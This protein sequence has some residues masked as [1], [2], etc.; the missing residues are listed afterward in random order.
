MNLASPPVLIASA[1]LL[2]LAASLLML[3]AHRRVHLLA[4]ITWL[5][6]SLQLATL[7]LCLQTL[8][9]GLVP[10][11]PLLP[12]LPGLHLALKPDHLSCALAFP[13]SVFWP[14]LAGFVHTVQTQTRQPALLLTPTGCQS[15]LALTISAAT[16]M[17]FAGNLPTLYLFYCLLILCSAPF[18]IAAKGLDETAGPV[19]S[20]LIALLAP[21]LLLMPVMALLLTLNNTLDFANPS[22]GLLDRQGPGWLVCLLFLASLFGFA[23]N[24]AMPCHRWLLACLNAPLPASVL[25]QTVLG[26]AGLFASARIML[27][28]FGSTLEDLHLDLLV[29]VLWGS[30]AV[31]AALLALCKDGLLDRLTWST[32]SQFACV[33][34]GLALDSRE[35]Q[36]AA[37]LLLTCH[38]A[39]KL[40]ALLAAAPLLTRSGSARI[41]ALAGLG[42]ELPLPA[43]LLTLAMLSLGG[44]PPLAGFAAL[45]P[46]LKGALAAHQPA[47]AVILATVAVLH[48][49]TFAPV[50]QTLFF[51]QPA[52]MG[53]PDSTAAPKPGLLWPLTLAGLLILIPGLLP[54]SALWTL[55]ET[56]RP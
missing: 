35:A 31:L 27:S 18:L 39:A 48:L 42:R 45:W 1:T 17:A 15:C 53:R 5:A 33:V 56:L 22:R 37:L 12:L 20:H 26:N 44:L 6:A 21:A 19:R 32:V 23:A 34:L 24:G 4:W 49:A 41:Q 36:A 2:P 8:Q 38:G 13:V 55:L 7:W 51:V 54:A 10:H 30:M 9:E 43:S 40:T 14:L 11:C 47:V 16:G 3:L 46:L 28:V 50:I 29:F 52:Q 25:A